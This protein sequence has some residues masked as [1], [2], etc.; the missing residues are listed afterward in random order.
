M[1]LSGK[2]RAFFALPTDDF[3]RESIYEVQNTLRTPGADVKWELPEKFHITLKFLGDVNPSELMIASNAIRSCLKDDESFGIIYDAVG[4]F[5]NVN[6][7]RVLWVGVEQNETIDH[8]QKI[9]EEICRTHH[10]GEEERKRF[11]PHI[12][13]GRVKS[14]R[15]IARLT[16]TLKNITF[17]PIESRCSE[18]LVMRSEL[19]PTGSR[20]IVLDSIPLRT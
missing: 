6:H 11:H 16:A 9:I 7:P 2:I 20:Y 15:G 1:T 17:E 4:A 10:L 13:L 18:V 14:E 12:T 5:P 8:V 19:L 3:V